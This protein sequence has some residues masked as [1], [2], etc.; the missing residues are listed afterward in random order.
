MKLNE[1]FLET[2]REATQLLQSGGPQ[3]AT[4]A[5]QR[6]LLGD[7]EQK[8]ERDPGAPDIVDINP[9]PSRHKEAHSSGFTPRS[10][11]KQWPDVT[12][13]TW[14]NPLE[15]LRQPAFKEADPHA[16]HQT[17]TPGRFLSASCTNQAGTRSY[18]LYI[19]SAYKGEALPMIVM[20]HGCKQNPDD[21]AAGTKMNHVAEKYNCFVVYPAQVKAANSSNCWQWFHPSDQAREG[22]EPSIIADI[23]RKVMHEY[24][25]DPDRVFIAGL[26]AGAAMAAIVASAYPELYAAVGIHSGLPVGSAHDV[27]SAFQAMKGGGKTI[28]KNPACHV[29]PAIVFHGERDHTVHPDN[30]IRTLAQCMNTTADVLQNGHL[31]HAAQVKQGKVAGGRSYIQTIYYDHARMPVAEYWTIH[32]AGHAWSGGSKRGSYTDPK[33]PDA[34]EEMLRFFEA[35]P[36]P[37][38]AS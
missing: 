27:P 35:H 36:H 31:A 24:R 11:S 9:T 32:G 28:R 15:T 20:L 1:K 10:F 12:D 37:R 29:V 22:T 26:S 16:D 38:K 13:I 25:V 17:Q 14:E 23:T 2:M 6:A 3:A 19:P 5:I 7:G 30:G 18:K 34:S 4:K 33:G 8:E 21:F